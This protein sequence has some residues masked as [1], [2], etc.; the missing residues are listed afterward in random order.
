MYGRWPWNRRLQA[1]LIERIFE[2]KPKVVAIDT[3]YPEPESPES[4]RAL[5]EVIKK[6]KTDLLLPLGLRLKKKGY[7]MGR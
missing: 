5:A 2:S 7:L 4:D 1:E 6:H 3:F